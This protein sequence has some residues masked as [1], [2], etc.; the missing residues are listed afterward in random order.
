MALHADTHE[1]GPATRLAG[2]RRHSEG[3]AGART[4]IGPSA[5]IKRQ[6]AT[7]RRTN[8]A[9]LPITNAG[10]GWDAI[11][12]IRR[13]PRTNA[14]QRKCDTQR[15]RQGS[16]RTIADTL[17]T[18]TVTLQGQSLSYTSGLTWH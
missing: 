18:L 11:R 12:D 5:T 3:S 13:M 14:V 15:W 4:G 9:T 6:Q 2:F 8:A 16:D 17:K 10:L 1:L 7:Q